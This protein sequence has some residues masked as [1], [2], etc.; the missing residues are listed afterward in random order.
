MQAVGP[1]RAQTIFA[2]QPLWAAMLNFAFIGEV[3][4]A[5]GFVGGGAFLGALVLA[6]TGEAPKPVDLAAADDA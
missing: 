2:S 1:T 5:Q 6:A 4:G 3:M